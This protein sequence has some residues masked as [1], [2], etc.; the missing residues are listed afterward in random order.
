MVETAAHTAIAA[1]ITVAALWPG[2]IVLQNRRAAAAP[3][4]ELS[5]WQSVIVKGLLLWIAGLW[6]LEVYRRF[7]AN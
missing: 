5:W 7:G 6:W 1:D 2:R 4:V 3:R